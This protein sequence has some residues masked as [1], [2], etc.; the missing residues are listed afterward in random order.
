MVAIDIMVVMA[1]II[2]IVKFVMFIMVMT[3]SGQTEKPGQT[4][5]QDRKI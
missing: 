1:M 5:I 4:G 3:S 2:I